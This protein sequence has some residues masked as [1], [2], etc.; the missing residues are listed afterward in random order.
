MTVSSSAILDNRSSWSRALQVL[1]AGTMLRLLLA[2]VV[3][4]TN[5]EAYYW[6]WSRR[7]AAG[8]FDHPP[9]IAWLVALG[10]DTPLGVRLG[11][12][13]AGTLAGLAI[14]RTARRL[15]GDDAAL[16]AS[17]IYACVP[18]AAAGYVLATPDAPLF[19]ALAWTLHAVVEALSAPLRSP[20][21]LRWWS[22]AGVAIGIAM[23]SK[24]TAVLI[25][26]AIALS[27]ALYA[28]LRPRLRE[29]GP[30]V[31]VGIASLV[32]APNLWWNATHE[33]ISFAFQLGHGLG[34]PKH[35]GVGAILTRELNLV[36]GQAGLTSP[37]LFV[38]FLIVIWRALQ[39]RDDAIHRL[40]GTVSVCVLLFFAWSAT[41]KN[42]E[43]NWPASAWL[44]A[45]ILLAVA[46]AHG[47]YTRWLRGG[48]WLGTALVL[49]V[50]A[51]AATLLAPRLGLRPGRDPVSQAYGWDVA[52]QDVHDAIRT[53]QVARQSEPVPRRVWVAADRYQQAAQLAWALQRAGLDTIG[54]FATNL[55]GRPNQ[56]DLWP[57]FRQRASQ[58]ET[59]VL[60]LDESDTEPP[61]I[62]ALAPYF[63]RIDQGPPVVRFAHGLLLGRQR[64]WL[65]RDWRGGWPGHSTPSIL[66]F[67]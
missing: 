6:E 27:V 38:L 8:Y 24:Y 20:A 4:L 16:W 32:L 12:V 64:A 10:G 37:I 36:G 23:L 51:D 19:C 35:A 26:A 21:S 15:G 7:L 47:A 53:A 39:Q 14:L 57:S 1:A 62:V 44:P 43:A 46:G 58:G 28:P 11:S 9:A 17:L 31:A 29:P 40:L 52:V 33:W 2:A 54:V 3:P 13:L 45:I 63:S 55:G 56:Y 22:V 30:Y 61:P 48:L 41:R 59:L 18:L 5:D 65:L 50:Y 60:V 25:P 34:A 67:R 66:E 49:V 42:V